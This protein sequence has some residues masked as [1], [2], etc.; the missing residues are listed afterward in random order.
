MKSKERESFINENKETIINLLRN[1]ELLDDLWT[2]GEAILDFEDIKNQV[3][4]LKKEN[5]D[6]EE[7]SELVGL[8]T[9]EEEVEEFKERHEKDLRTLDLL[10]EI[11]ENGIIDA[12]YKTLEKMQ[13]FCSFNPGYHIVTMIDTDEGVSY[14]NETC[15]VNRISYYF[16]KGLEQENICCDLYEA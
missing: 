2:S 11:D 13:K 6:F 10:E 16:A 3:E 7:F 15:L 4:L 5:L 1:G 14:V 9:E 12:N 8:I